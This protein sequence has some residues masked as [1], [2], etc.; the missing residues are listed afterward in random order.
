VNNTRINGDAAFVEATAA[1]NQFTEFEELGMQHITNATEVNFQPVQQL[2]LYGAYRFSTRRIRTRQL[3]QFS[4]GDFDVPLFT[5]DNDIHSGVAGFRWRPVRELRVSFDVEAGN[6]DQPMTPVSDK[7]FHAETFRLQWRKNG[8]VFGGSFKSRENDISASFI[9]HSTTGRS[10]G[11]NTSWSPPSGRFTLDAA[12]SRLDLDTA[13]GI[14]NFFG[15]D[16]RNPPANSYYAS[17][18]H[19]LHLGSRA[20]PHPRVTLYF[21]YNLAKD[22]GDDFDSLPSAA[23]FDPAYPNAGFDGA[24]LFNSFPLTYHSPLA[25]LSVG[26]RDWLSWNLG[27]QFY[28]YDERFTG[29]QNYH[30]HVAY[31]SFRWSF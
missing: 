20:Q 28:N 27:Y 25:R 2:G 3:F 24:S 1:V 12:Y 11:L 4:G 26:L 29:E 17:N 5:Q 15:A 22:T 10:W 9:N 31:S 8:L 30:A 21:G 13:S 7:R 18:L 6:A 19:N 23:G 16:V 14:L